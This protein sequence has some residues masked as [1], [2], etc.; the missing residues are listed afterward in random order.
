MTWARVGRGEVG[1][2]NPGGVVVR[3]FAGARVADEASIFWVVNDNF[4]YCW[5]GVAWEVGQYKQHW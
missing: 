1:Q 2:N 3:V 4:R 5:A